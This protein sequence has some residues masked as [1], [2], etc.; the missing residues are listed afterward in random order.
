MRRWTVMT[1]VLLVSGFA[2]AGCAAG[3]ESPGERASA[4]ATEESE[5]DV[6]TIASLEAIDGAE[7]FSS[8]G[9]SVQVPEGWT[10]DRTEQEEFVQIVVYDPADEANPVGI[11]VGSSDGEE[12]SISLESEVT[13]TQLVGAG[14]TAVEQHSV[15]WDSWAYAVG[16]TGELANSAGSTSD[17]I[18][19]STQDDGESMALTV[20]AQSSTSDVEDSL[21]YEV[22]RTVRP[23]P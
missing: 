20:S 13:M 11:T 19:V 10:A 8:D 9:I 6:L 22:L 23:A 3:S 4:P 15:D 2:V 12:S 1:G 18:S 16:I 5:G 7:E 17:F 14:A 21:Q